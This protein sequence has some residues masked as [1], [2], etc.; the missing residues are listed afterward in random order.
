[1]IV[2]LLED[3]LGRHKDRSATAQ[4]AIDLLA[5]RRFKRYLRILKSGQ[6]RIDRNAV[7]EADKYDGKWVIETMT[8]PSVLKTPPAATRALW[9]SSATSVP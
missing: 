7:R 5:S 6:V 8:T 2:E 3:E 9:S 1:M 4:W